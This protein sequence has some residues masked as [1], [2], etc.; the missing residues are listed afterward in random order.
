MLLSPR[1]DRSFPSTGDA[2]P[3]YKITRPR[4]ARQCDSSILQSWDPVACPDAANAI[5]QKRYIVATNEIGVCGN[6]P[7]GDDAQQ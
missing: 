7:V 5:P 3:R 1:D 4:T 2:G 6:R